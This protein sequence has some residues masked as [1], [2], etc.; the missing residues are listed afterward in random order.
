MLEYPLFSC[1]FWR[2]LCWCRDFRWCQTKKELLL[3]N[4]TAAVY[5]KAQLIR[6][7]SHLLCPCSNTVN[8]KF[9][10]K[11]TRKIRSSKNNR[12]AHLSL[13]HLVS[14]GKTQAIRQN[15]NLN[16]RSLFFPPCNGPSLCLPLFLPCSIHFPSFS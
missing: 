8:Y 4:A 15:S 11:A 5:T 7:S 9:Q 2:P 1:T 16:C 6:E 14:S 12:D 3:L 13:F 10:N